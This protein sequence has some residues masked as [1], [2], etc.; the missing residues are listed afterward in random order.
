MPLPDAGRRRFPAEWEPQSGVQL[1]WPHP[2]GDWQPILSDV[3]PVFA[4]IGAAIARRE[5]LLVVCR[6]HV[7]WSGIQT[8][9]VRRGAPADSLLFG[10][11]P[12]ND[13][14]ARDHGPLT[15]I[16]GGRAQL[17][18]FRFNGWGGK[19]AAAAD[20]AITARLTR[21]GVF[22][23]ASV[24][25]SDLVLEGGALETDGQGTLLATRHA[26]ITDTRNPGVTQARIEQ[27][28]RHTLGIERFL[29][30]DHG[31]LTGDD[32][33]GHID[34][35]ARFSDPWTIVYAT[36]ARED[37]DFSELAQMR[38]ELER[39]TR[40]DGAPYRL[41]P[42][43]PPGVLR[44]SDGRRLPATYANF[45]ILN[46]AVLAPVYGAEN[47]RRAL[48]ILARCFRGRQIVSVDARPIIRQNGSLHCLT[49]HYPQALQLHCTES[50]SSRSS[51]PD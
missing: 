21:A 4:R 31:R 29:W 37:P 20:D 40:R 46:G 1:T 23:D 35:L 9:L 34:T 10:L 7:Q 8:Q 5:Q 43:P 44:D 47:D 24:E 19:F 28:L 33:D 51:G 41:I 50:A 16:V 36:C 6:S 32:T 15:V 18:D 45:L 39:F 3:E 17:I 12:S 13:T 26:V 2:D 14:W 42:L 38:Q 22:G 48:A 30:L 25:R 49:M 11:S 27:V